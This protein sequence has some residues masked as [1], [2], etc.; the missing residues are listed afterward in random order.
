MTKHPAPTRK[1]HEKFCIT[2]GW[3]LVSDARGRAVGHHTT[4]KLVTPTGDVLRTRISHPVNRTTYAPAM[5]SHILRDQLHVAADE[6]WA[7]ALDGSRPD[8]GAP[9][10]PDAALPLP[11]VARLVRE[12]GLSREEIAG[13]GL[14]E[15]RKL[16]KHG[17]D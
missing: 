5:W 8:R 3:T 9:V 2:E 12:L 10:V 6:F 4:Y 13:L 15:A 11:L 1:H 14:D 17:R 7:C 16:L